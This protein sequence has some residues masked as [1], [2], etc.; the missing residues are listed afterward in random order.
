MARPGE[1]AGRGPPDPC[2]SDYLSAERLGGS[3]FE[4]R[5]AL[6][7]RT[8]RFPATCALPGE[9]PRC[10]V[11]GSAESVENKEKKE[12]HF[13]SVGRNPSS[14]QTF[15]YEQGKWLELSTSTL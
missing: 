13:V 3:V 10:Q 4:S 14:E 5:E 7:T 2:F 15:G 9:L 8:Y 6:E 12:T 11:T 1:A